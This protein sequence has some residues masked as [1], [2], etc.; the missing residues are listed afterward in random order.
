MNM[1]NEKDTITEQKSGLREDWL[2][3][4]FTP[5]EGVVFT[6]ES[7][8]EFHRSFADDCKMQLF[9]EPIVV[10][11]ENQN[12][13]KILPG[14]YSVHDVN[15]VGFWRNSNSSLYKY[16]EHPVGTVVAHTCKPLDIERAI[17]GISD[18][19]QL[20]RLRYGFLSTHKPPI[21]F[22]EF[23]PE[24]TRKQLLF[25]EIKELITTVDLEDANHVWIAG[26]NLEKLVLEAAALFQG[27]LAL[28]LHP[29]LI[30]KSQKLYELWEG[31]VEQRFAQ[32]VIEGRKTSITEHPHFKRYQRLTNKEIA[33]SG[34]KT[35]TSVAMCGPGWDAITATLYATT[36]A[37]VTCFEQDPERAAIAR[38]VTAKLGFV[39]RIRIVSGKAEDADMEG[40]KVI[41]L[42][43]LTQRKSDIL[44]KVKKTQSWDYLPNVIMRTTNGEKTLL[45]QNWGEA[46]QFFIGSRSYQIANYNADDPDDIISGDMIVVIPGKRY[47]DQGHT[48]LYLLNPSLDE[49]LTQRS[50][51][52]SLLLHEYLTR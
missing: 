38:Q 18:Y 47:D 15:S 1:S 7:V 41:T 50:K 16:S 6:P 49:E 21:N 20:D 37:R 27:R 28:I 22:T 44:L 14:S 45:Y 51:E 23:I 46:R 10:M 29:D 19:W 11:P 30:A 31:M 8:A 35:D 9:V 52:A 12:Q 33:L 40:F 34:I 43:A 48:D 17:Q 2:T 4:R 25:S 39:D 24:R 3:V 13:F 5:P 42:A 32:D 26:K 36:G